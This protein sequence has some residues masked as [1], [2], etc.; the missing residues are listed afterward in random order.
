MRRI[1]GA[2]ILALALTGCGVGETYTRGQKI[3][4]DQLEQVPV[5]SSREQVLLAL[6]TPTTT[7]LTDGE[8][9]YYISQTA[10][11]SFAYQRAT[12]QDRRI[13]VV[14]LDDNGEVREMAEYGMKDGKVFDYL[15]RRTPTGGSDLAF[16]SQLLGGLINPAL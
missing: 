11:R 3:T 9:F 16:V 1:A 5:G 4:P 14:Y 10:T 15:A 8:A 7:G 12:V 13:L 6:G 2:A